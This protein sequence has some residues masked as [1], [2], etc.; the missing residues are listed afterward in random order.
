V[1]ELDQSVRERDGVGEV[2]N[3]SIVSEIRKTKIAFKKLREKRVKRGERCFG[4]L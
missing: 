2:M 3:Y 4:D 1:S